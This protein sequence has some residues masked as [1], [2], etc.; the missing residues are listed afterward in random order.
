MPS[1]GMQYVHRKL[2]RSVIETRRSVT[3]RP[4]GSMSGSGGVCTLR[5]YATSATF[6]SAGIDLAPLY[7]VPLP[8][9]VVGLGAHRG[10]RT[11]TRDHSDTSH[12][13]RGG[14]DPQA[15][16]WSLELAGSQSETGPT[17]TG[18]RRGAGCLF[19]EGKQMETREQI[20]RRHRRPLVGSVVLGAAA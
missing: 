17:P 19:P 5:A 1:W 14:I 18:S 7:V 6:D 12:H 16:N 13:L 10:D 8:L 4:K 20:R 9:L 3:R 2:Q 15:P 11:S